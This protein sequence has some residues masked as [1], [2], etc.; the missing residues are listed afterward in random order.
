M[1]IK[2]KINNVNMEAHLRCMYTRKFVFTID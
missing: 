1:K 2:I